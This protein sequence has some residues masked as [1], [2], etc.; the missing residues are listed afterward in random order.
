MSAEDIIE[1][2]FEP[3]VSG[4]PNGRPVGAKTGLRA[5]LMRIMDQEISPDL[6]EQ[7]RLKGI[8]LEDKDHAELIAILLKNLALKSDLQA[9]KLIFEQT[10]SPMPK[11]MK[12]AGELKVTRIERVIKNGNL[13]N[14][15]STDPGT[16]AGTE[17]V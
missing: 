11:E 14:R 5:R 1:H 2:Q 9:I 8:S 15:D 3:G 7:L 13:T 6:L 12:L 17:P 16:D 10:E 4:N